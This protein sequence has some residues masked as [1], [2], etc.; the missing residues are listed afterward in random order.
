MKKFVQDFIPRLGTPA[1]IYELFHGLEYPEEKILDTSYKRKM[2]E[3]GFSKEEREKVDSIYTVF[4]YDG[5]VQIFLVEAKILSAPF[6]KQITKRFSGRYLKFLLIL[7]TDYRE[8]AF[9]F[10]EF[11]RI[12]EGRHKLKLTRLVFDRE[13]TCYTDLL[14]ISNLA[15]TGAEKNWRDIWLTW[16]DAFRVEKV[17]GRFFE[18]YKKVFFKLRETFDGENIPVKDA[19]ELAQQFLNRL[20]FLYFIAKK[21]WLNDDPKFIRWYWRRYRE[22]KRHQKAQED[23]FYANWLRPLFLEAFNN[24]FGFRNSPHLP[25]DVK[26]VLGNAPYLNGG[27]F[28]RNPLDDLPFQIS[29]LLFGEVFDFLEQYNFTIRE[30]LPLD[31]FFYTSR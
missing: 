16:K 9:V 31:L 22:E 10:P 14:T 19:H 1:Q 21:R 30:E 2:S 25:N 26:T 7:T 13:N 17:A 8:F 4:N 23:T 11:E 27:L 6:I 20:M 18:N 5:K 28:A 12:S 15:L 3:F 24:N 29:D